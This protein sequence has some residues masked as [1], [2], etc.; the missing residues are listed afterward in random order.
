MENMCK[1]DLMEFIRRTSFAMVELALYLDTHPGC[2]CGLE[3]YHD[4]HRAYHKA[5][6]LYEKKYGPITIYGVYDENNWAWI[7]EPWPWQ[8]E[9]E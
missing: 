4:Y 8:K 6:N 1:K 3:T 5:L 2:S 9:C 7:D